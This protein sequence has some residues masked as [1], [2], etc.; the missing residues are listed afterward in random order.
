[1]AETE[2]NSQAP[3]QQ[4]F[5]ARAKDKIG[6]L[7]RRRAND[8][9]RGNTSSD[10]VSSPIIEPFQEGTTALAGIREALAAQTDP[11][12]T[13][14]EEETLLQP[15]V[16]PDTGKVI[17]DLAVFLGDSALHNF[18]QDHKDEQS[19]IR[20]KL[21]PHIEQDQAGFGRVIYTLGDKTFAFRG[22]EE[23]PYYETMRRSITHLVGNQPRHVKEMDYLMYKADIEKA[24]LEHSDSEHVVATKTP[25]GLVE[26]AM[27]MGSETPQ[28]R[29]LQ[30]K[31]LERNYDQQVLALLDSM[32][33][34][35][36]IDEP[37][38]GF[39]Q[40]QNPHAD[41]LVLL[42]LMGDTSAQAILGQNLQ[43]LQ[44]KG[45]TG[46]SF[47]GN[48]QEVEPLRVEELMC[49]HATNY[50]P[51]RNGHG[52]YEIQTTYDA[53]GRLLRNSVHT[54][55]NH[56]VEDIF[57]TGDWGS[58]DYV[59]L[60]PFEDMMR[61]NGKPARIN[62]V[63]TWWV[64]NPGEKLTFPDATLVEP[65]S[66]AINGLFEVSDGGRRVI[67]KDGNYTFADIKLIEEACK[68]KGEFK[69][70]TFRRNV[71]EFLLFS[72][73][74]PVVTQ[75]TK[76]M[77]KIDPGSSDFSARKVIYNLYGDAV[78]R[79]TTNVFDLLETMS[80][81]GF[82]IREAAARLLTKANLTSEINEG[83]G[84]ES[85][86]SAYIDSA[87]A[88]LFQTLKAEI[89]RLAVEAAIKERGFEVKP[90][91]HHAWGDSYAVTEQT[92]SLGEEL[93]IEYGQHAGTDEAKV[94]EEYMESLRRAD[95]SDGNNFTWVEYDPSF[96]ALIPSISEQTRRMIVDAG[97]LVARA[98]E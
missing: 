54:T 65:A 12:F 63:D 26:L 83:V 41:A 42:A 68:V 35:N 58:T 2:K 38:E 94:T 10:I 74:N 46:P 95:G 33:A 90:T 24:S 8:P 55:L 11:S 32:V 67:F 39:R 15:I 16:Y 6:R 86:M 69:Y 80:S 89:N 29:E 97:V 47:S 57:A 49:V 84:E 31:I 91:G 77:W 88:T 7:F 21:S 92:K 82:S 59:V 79:Y 14:L 18:E 23:L 1:M 27:A 4:H 56:K 34:A 62:T 73:Y 72:R 44:E 78:N 28:L 37:E 64:R 60:S 43:T 76:D 13:T 61:A 51:T 52:G 36:Y 87:V 19:L 5:T 85:A 22:R 45:A 66:E 40:E 53:A 48:T 30:E 3:E 17:D 50:H 93:R 9:V 70:I 98:V 20:E 96:T 81:E 25:L 75:A 71:D